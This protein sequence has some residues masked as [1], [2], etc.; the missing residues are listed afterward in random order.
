MTDGPKQSA[1]GT[2][3]LGVFEVRK[4]PI[5][6]PDHVR[7]RHGRADCAFAVWYVVFDNGGGV[8]DEWQWGYGLSWYHPDPNV[9]TYC[10]GTFDQVL[11]PVDDVAREIVRFVVDHAQ[12]DRDRLTRMEAREK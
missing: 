2:S 4:H 12:K 5:T 8:D 7:L 1:L 10:P 3:V 11:T 6:D 9:Q